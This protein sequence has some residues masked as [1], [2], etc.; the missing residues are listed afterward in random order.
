MTHTAYIYDAIR[1]PRGKGKKDGSL[2]EIKPVAL[3]AG[4]LR[5]LQQRYDLDTSRVDDVVMGCVNPTGEQGGDVAKNIVDIAGWDESVPGVQLDRFCASGLEAVNMAA[6]KIASGWEDLVV[7][8]GV[9]SLS[10]VPMGTTG[11][12]AISDPETSIQLSFVPQGIGADM[13]ATIGGWGREEVDAFALQSQ[14]RATYA[15]DN[16]YFDRSVVP[17]KDLNGMVVLAKDE[18]IKP[19][20]TLEGLSGLKPSFATMGNMGF[21]ELM[22]RKYP[23]YPAVNHVH[24]PGNCSGIVDGASAVLIGSEQAGKDLG[25]IPRGRIISTAV[26]ATDPI[27]MLTG[28]GPAAAK[29]LKKAGMTVKDIDLFEINEA[30][31]SISLRF[32]DDLG[33]SSEITNVNG[34]AIAMGHPLGATGAMLIGTMLDELER[35]KLKRGLVALCVGG[36]QG[37]ATIIER[38]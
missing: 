30:F 19:Q 8:G 22:L 21:D 4:L 18:F 7:A 38:V 20:T 5:E 10:R 32:M 29:A 3:G 28:P 26:I 34:G 11:G 2:H 14:Q 24:T 16:G 6:M 36:G 15:R 25:L 13:I 37:I 1:T 23:Q 27:I 9:E 35:R 12:A 33:I 17:V 31:A